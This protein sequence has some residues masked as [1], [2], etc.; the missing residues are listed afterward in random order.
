MPDPDESIENQLKDENS[1][2]SKL[3]RASFDWHNNL[4][5]R[6][7]GLIKNKIPP[8][9]LENCP[10]KFSSSKVFMKEAIVIH[11]DNLMYASD[12]IKSDP[13]MLDSVRERIE[14]IN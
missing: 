10:K 7:V 3:L 8:Y 9:P 4:M 11:P 13:D 5:A 1:E 6:E 14:G 12:A 2:A